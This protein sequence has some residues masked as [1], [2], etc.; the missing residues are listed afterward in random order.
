MYVLTWPLPV[1]DQNAADLTTDRRFFE[2]SES[3][4]VSPYTINDFP[5]SPLPETRHEI[6]DQKLKILRQIPVEVV[7]NCGSF[8]SIILYNVLGSQRI[9]D[10]SKRNPETFKN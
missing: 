5:F 10:S 7:I 1:H 3:H 4:I 6:F 8:K 2:H 9:D